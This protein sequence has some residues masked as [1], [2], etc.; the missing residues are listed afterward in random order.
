MQLPRCRPLLSRVLQLGS[1]HTL[2]TGHCAS[3]EGVPQVP[4]A[5]AAAAAPQRCAD[6]HTV[7]QAPEALSHL[8]HIE[9]L[10]LAILQLQQAG[11]AG[12]RKV[13]VR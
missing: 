4:E 5:L 13:R 9:F 12:L 3:Q 2:L 6:H 1:L 11:A 8:E 10:L 7:P